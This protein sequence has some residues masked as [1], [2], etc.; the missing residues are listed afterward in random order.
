MRWITTGNLIRAT[1]RTGELFFAALG[2]RGKQAEIQPPQ[3]QRILVV[4]LD[5][6]GD[7]VLTSPFLRE[8]RGFFPSTWITLIVKPALVN[9]V[10][11]CPHVNEVLTYDWNTPGRSTRLRRHGRALKLAWEHL[12]KRR[13]DLAIL[14]RWGPDYYHGAFVL[15]FS[16]APWRVGYSESVSEEKRRRNSGFDH[17]LT[18]LLFDTTPK[19][20]VERNLEVLHFLGAKIQESDLEL[21]LGRED[22]AF[23]Q[24]ILESHGVL[25]EDSLVAFAPGAGAANRLWPILN[26]AELGRW[27]LREY[28]PR[29]VL[30]GGTQDRDFGEYFEGQLCDRVVN[31]IGRTTLRQAAALLRLCHLFLGNDAGPMHLAAACGLPVVEISCHPRGGSPLHGNSPLRFG[32]WGVPHIVLQP[33]RPLEPC[34]DACVSEHAHCILGVSVEQAREAIGVLASQQFAFVSK[35]GASH[36]GASR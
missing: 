9:L 21:W 29:I 32:P 28:H 36:R 15:Y 10:E 12:W 33:E 31:A 1:H 25:P 18:H 23:A 16:G 4:R 24:Q 26:F 22:E 19:H 7:M 6:I 27:L 8:L 11:L 2:R 20:E 34:K 35:R 14:P 17:L 3:V 5:E 13:F 30:V